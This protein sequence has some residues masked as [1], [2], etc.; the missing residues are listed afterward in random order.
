[1]VF[2]FVL[3][4][5]KLFL[6]KTPLPL[7]LII[8]FALQVVTAV[9]LTGWLSLRH[10][11]QAVSEMADQLRDE[12][13]ER[14]LQQL[15]SYV[16]VPQHLVSDMALT[17]QLGI[18]DWQDFSEIERF[19]WLNLQQHKSLF[20]A[21]LGLETGAVVSV[22]QVEGKLASRIAQPGTNRLY[23]YELVGQ[24]RRGEQIM[25]YDF[26]VKKR[27]WYTTAVT[28]GQ[29]TW[30]EIYPSYDVPIL[31]ISAVRPIYAGDGELIGVANAAISLEQISEFLQALEVSRVGATFI[32]ERSGFL[33][34]SSTS[35]KLYRTQEQGT[36]ETRERLLATDSQDS[37]VR[38]TTQHLLEA[39][40]DL[41]SIEQSQE[42]EFQLNGQQQ[43]VQVTPFADPFGIDWLTL[44]VVP[45]ST[46]ME[47]IWLNRRVTLAFCLITLM[48]AVYAGAITVRLV[49]R[50]L[51]W[52]NQAA[53][54][55]A[56]GNLS[57]TVSANYIAEVRE[58]AQSFNWMT[59]QLQDSFSRLRTLNR[60]L[61]AKES[62]LNQFLEALP[63]G[64]SV[65]DL[66][67]RLV[68][69]NQVGLDLLQIE[70]PLSAVKEELATAY[71][72]YY[73]KTQQLYKSEDLP[74]V[75]ALAGETVHTD[76][77]EFRRGS[78]AVLLEVHATPIY[79]AQGEIEGAITTF[80][81][82]RDRKHTEEQ[83]LYQ[84]LHDSLTDLPNRSFLMQRLQSALEQVH[85]NPDHYFALLFLDLDR[86]K[87]INDSLGHL[88]GD[89]LLV[90]LAQRLQ[91][92]TRAQDL[93][94]RLGGDE[95]VIL[96][97]HLQEMQDPVAVAQRIFAQ[98][99]RPVI[100]AGREIFVSTSIG[101]VFGTH[102]YMKAVDLLRD[103]DIALHRA[104]AKGR[105][106]YEIFGTP[107]H[108]QV[109]ERLHLEQDLYQ[110]LENQDLS[111]YYQPIV[112]IDTG[113][114]VGF[115]ALARWY[116]PTRGFVCPSEFIQ[117][118]E[119][120]DLIVSLDHWMLQQAS[121][122]LVQWQN[123]FQGLETLKVSVNLAV[124]T[125]LDSHLLARIQQ[126]LEQTGL[127]KH[128]L[129][130]EITESSLIPDIALTND[131]LSKLRQ[132]GI[133]ISIDD[134]GTGYSSLSYLQDLSADTLKIDGSF[135][136]QMPSNNR[137]Y[138]LVKMIIT[139]THQLGLM[140]VA[141]GI[142]TLQHMKQLRQL[143]CQLGQGYYFSAPLSA[144][145]ATKLLAHRRTLP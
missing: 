129:T 106:C 29:T 113:D 22:G 137:N 140:T 117:M 21:S 77:L 23:T 38:A 67:G 40:G 104:K 109:V 111:I 144:Q 19:L 63:V 116:H 74:V 139:I 133:Q 36:R 68:Y 26:D 96:L 79:N 120:T 61:A 87:V 30:T 130:L 95:F 35:E 53:R 57:Q 37:L 118:A 103:A 41:S 122:Q 52:L 101:I 127:A 119:E 7:V 25:V 145:A 8:P 121:Q 28:A 27:P 82:I 10:G 48:L 55:V 89:E 126:T 69:T 98:L 91:A 18:L 51:Q 114:I 46:L 17:S 141:E 99:Q 88:V 125:L 108:Q 80:Q 128:C 94:A 90:S 97:E 64:V 72:V 43:F 1:M 131:L 49:S 24:G 13:T 15:V 142:R 78:E 136:R 65:H 3:N 70:Q 31:Q 60:A 33:V 56:Q 93:A 124:R 85:Q 105:N 50:P 86:F 11:Q 5:S 6:Q 2:K 39:V 9:G 14:I 66:T 54:N 135:V 62:R 143:G 100:L 76:N 107:M 110:A 45:K 83:L 138:N 73:P 81:D 84:S 112:K 59:M 71:Q 75:R 134:F 123:Q 115:E 102:Q 16:N 4:Q 44:V 132:Q 42:F 34:A 47:E 20:I 32:I 12:Q 92:V 58:L